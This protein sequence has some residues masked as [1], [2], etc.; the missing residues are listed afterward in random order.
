MVATWM[1][2]DRFFSASDGED[3][4]SLNPMLFCQHVISYCLI[5]TPPAAE[6]AYCVKL[7]ACGTIIVA[8]QVLETRWNLSRAYNKTN[9]FLLGN[10]SKFCGQSTKLKQFVVEFGFLGHIYYWPDITYIQE[11]LLF[12]V[13]NNEN[14]SA[15]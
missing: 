8:E 9:Y 6:I 4:K 10:K 13:R 12:P 7:T 15:F 14:W 1:T 11:Y 5:A 3:N 2:S